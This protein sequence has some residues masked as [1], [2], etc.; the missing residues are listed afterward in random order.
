[1]NPQIKYERITVK[2]SQ[3]KGVEPTIPL[4]EPTNYSEM[5]RLRQTDLLIGEMFINSN[6]HKV[7]I[8]TSINTIK[9]LA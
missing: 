8:R 5:L 6:D 1:M 7:W 9:R 2:S 3:I 4:I